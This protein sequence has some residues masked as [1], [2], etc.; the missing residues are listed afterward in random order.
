MQDKGSVYVKEKNIEK[1]R[2]FEVLLF[3]RQ[4]GNWQIKTL[5]SSYSF[6]NGA[7]GFPD[8][9]SDCSTCTGDQCNSCTKSVKYSKAHDPNSCGYDSGDGNNWKEGVYTRVHRDQAIINAMRKWMGLS[10]ESDPTRLG[11]SY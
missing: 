2:G 6:T 11:L 1:H 10:E 5:L 9:M 3:D 7:Q 4:D 8:G